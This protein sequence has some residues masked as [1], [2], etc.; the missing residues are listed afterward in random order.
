MR[1]KRY[2]FLGACALI[3]SLLLIGC[4]AQDVHNLSQDL[5]QTAQH[6]GEALNNAK[7]AASVNSVLIQRKGV[8]MSG[9]HVEAKDGVVTL[10]GHVRSTHERKLIVETVESVRGV[11]KVINNLHVQSGS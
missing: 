2:L 6:T 1:N 8:D 5:G 7:L 10:G 4:N 11:N 3:G 9:L